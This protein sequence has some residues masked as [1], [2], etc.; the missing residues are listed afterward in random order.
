MA[1]AIRNGIDPNNVP[2]AIME[3]PMLTAEEIM[4]IA[5][6]SQVIR[7]QI[8][9]TVGLL[10]E[11]LRRGWF[12]TLAFIYGKAFSDNGKIL[13]SA[14]NA[15]AQ[16]NFLCLQNAHRHH[17][18]K[19][20]VQEKRMES[21]SITQCGIPSDETISSFA[22]K[23]LDILRNIPTSLFAH[24]RKMSYNCLRLCISFFELP[25]PSAPLCVL[26]ICPA[27]S[28]LE[29]L[30][31]PDKLQLFP[32]SNDS[33]EWVWNRVAYC[34]HRGLLYDEHDNSFRHRVRPTTFQLKNTAGGDLLLANFLQLKCFQ[35]PGTR[36][37][38]VEVD[39][40][41]VDEMGFHDQDRDLWW[42]N[43]ESGIRE[44]QNEEE[45]KPNGFF[46]RIKP[47]SMSLLGASV[48]T[49]L[50][51]KAGT[52]EEIEKKEAA[53][54]A[55]ATK[56][57]NTLKNVGN[58]AFRR[59]NFKLARRHYEQ[60]IVELRVIAGTP[61]KKALQLVG[62]L[63][64]NHAVC[65]LA[66]A[67]S[68][69]PSYGA[70]TLKEVVTVCTI[71][72]QNNEIRGAASATILERLRFRKELALSR[73]PSTD[74]GTLERTDELR[75]DSLVQQIDIEYNLRLFRHDSAME[76]GKKETSGKISIQLGRDVKSSCND[77]CPVCYED[78]A[79][80][81]ADLYV[82]EMECGHINC[83]KCF[84]EWNRQATTCN[85]CREEV[86]AKL[87][88][89]ALGKICKA[90]MNTEKLNFLPLEAH[91]E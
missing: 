76:E 2:S 26:V 52:A 45:R 84:L 22:P 34:I 49:L 87:W 56:R 42:P 65:G 72:L 68:Q 50:E 63:L 66:Y 7:D 62:S 28:A 61:G 4:A 53:Q 81:L 6:Q 11:A 14:L 20:Q 57:A 67:K 47:T 58:E 23:A 54:T 24:K 85:I 31:I 43:V 30:R 69:T 16:K 79:T 39:E 91:E 17:Q 36:V 32:F 41:S 59:D 13:M 35:L 3:R 75:G 1:F 5:L 46:A 71:A 74:P 9:I 40:T 64:S 80:S 44:L 86:T 19:N 88:D 25:V 12:S 21:T 8:S 51:R 33:F 15:R 89:E 38:L 48:S 55:K 82:I 37:Q 77:I 73:Q 70:F 18:I 78:F 29:I 83:A 27:T 10:N 90:T 60:G